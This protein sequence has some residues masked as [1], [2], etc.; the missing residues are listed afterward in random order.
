MHTIDSTALDVL[1]SPA[2]AEAYLVD[3]Y[4]TGG[5]YRLSNWPMDMQFITPEA[6]T[7]GFGEAGPIIIPADTKA[8]YTGLGPQFAIGQIAASEDAGPGQVTLS[9]PLVPG[10][11]AATLGNVESYRGRRARIR[12]QVL[13]PDTLQP[14][15]APVPLYVGE[16]QPVKVPRTSP[17]G[18]GGPVGGRIEMQLT[19][20]GTSNARRNDGARLTDTQQQQRH[21]GDRGLEYVQALVR[22]ETPWLTIAFQQSLL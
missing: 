5:T 16:M 3:L 21:P 17:S 13:H 12:Y 7:P 20:A 14:V 4:F 2:Y 1:Q 6:G 22:G 8:T 9:I 18:L 19:R 10:M 11:L 15:G